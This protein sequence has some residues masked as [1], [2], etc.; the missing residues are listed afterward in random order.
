MAKEYGCLPSQLLRLDEAND[1]YTAF[2]FDE[3]C[4]MWGSFVESELDQ[5]GSQC[6]DSSQI[7]SYRLRRYEQLMYQ[8]DESQQ[9]QSQPT[10]VVKPVVLLNED[11]KPNR[12]PRGRFRDPASI[13]QP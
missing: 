9:E 6:K 12:S 10:P 4:H 2:C 7:N 3:A 8:Q 5:A 11:N 13:G 1:P